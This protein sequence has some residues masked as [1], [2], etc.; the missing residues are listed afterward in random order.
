MWVI[1]ETIKKN[2]KDFTLAPVNC[3]DKNMLLHYPNCNGECKGEEAPVNHGRPQY[4]VHKIHLSDIGELFK[5]TIA[6]AFL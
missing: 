4:P 5:L 6:N 2:K 1:V 3:V